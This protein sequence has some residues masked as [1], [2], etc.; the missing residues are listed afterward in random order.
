[1][2]TVGCSFELS[3]ESAG[4]MLVVE[5]SLVD[6]KAKCKLYARNRTMDEV[7]KLI[8]PKL[9]KTLTMDQSLDLDRN[10]DEI[11]IKATDWRTVLDELASALKLRIEE[12][13]ETLSLASG[14]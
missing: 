7:L 11:D 10:V 1:M 9:T 4:G 14:G 13:D 12:N 3:R 8:E 5:D 6:G 2:T